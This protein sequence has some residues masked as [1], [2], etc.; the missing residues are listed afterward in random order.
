MEAR[1][2][3]YEILG[4]ARDAD[5]RTI[6]KAYRQIAMRDHPDRN[7]GDD[8]AEARFKEASEAYA[9]LSDSDQRARYDRYGHAGL[10][11]GAPDMEDVFSHFGDIFADIFGGGRR[12]ADP[13]APR[14]GDD[15]QTALRVPFRIA[16]HGG[17]ETLRVPRSRT[18]GTCEG[19]GARPGTG[20]TTCTMCGG[21]GQ[22][23]RSQGLFVIQT[24]CPQCHGSG[25]MVES[26]CE[27][28]NGRGIVRE[29]AEVDVHI[30]RGVDSGVRLRLRGE[31]AAGVNGGPPG[32]LFVV[33][34]VEPSDVFQRNGADLHLPLPID[35]TVALLGGTLEIPTVDG[36]HHTLEIPA[37]VQPGQAI[38]LDGL[39]LP[40]LNRDRRGSL[41]VH[42][43]VEIPRKLSRKERELIEELADL[44]AANARKH[45]SVFDRIRSLFEPHRDQE[46]H[47]TDAAPHD[48]DEAKS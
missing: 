41:H 34:E 36:E 27:D 21:S 32:D 26:P 19:T 9:V 1:R 46:P 12:R 31:G 43:E 47:R 4:V 18:C 25:S 17:T 20:R 29:N 15:L 33:L 38:R 48:Q 24:T 45:T 14:R 16:V 35:F 2:D 6:K 28:C 13:N 23:R 8:A 11:G 7:P 30:P 44:R 37:G 22:I 42:L 5:D 39:G 3:Y 40:H 10:Q